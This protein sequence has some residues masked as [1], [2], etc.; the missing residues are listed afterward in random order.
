MVRS[1][2]IVYFF[3]FANGNFCNS[4]KYFNGTIII[5]PS[6]NLS[7]SFPAKSKF[8]FSIQI[9]LFLSILSI[10]DK[11]IVLGFLPPFTLLKEAINS[12]WLS[13][14]KLT[15]L[16]NSFSV[17]VPLLAIISVSSQIYADRCRFPFSLTT[18]K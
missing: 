14:I 18:C 6:S 2:T 5:R 15:A 3:L 9:L 1:S 7:D 17:S 4:G 8:N 13:F 11:F 10:Y 12:F 16:F